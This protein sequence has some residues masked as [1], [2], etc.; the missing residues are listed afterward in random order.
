MYLS[1][2]AIKYPVFTTMVITALGV[3]GV[4][5]LWFLGVEL[6]PDVFPPVVVVS[7]QY[8]GAD[9][10]EMEKLVTRPI[11]DVV[12]ALKG[13]KQV[14]SV[15]TVGLSRVVVEFTLETPPAE[16]AFRVSEALSAIR[17]QLPL[18]IAE[19]SI[20][21]YDPAVEPIMLLGL[22]S[23][24][25]EPDQ[26]HRIALEDIKP[27]L[28]PLDGVASVE[29]MGGIE[30]EIQVLVDGERLVANRLSLHQVMK[31]LGEENTSVP[32]G[33]ILEPTGEVLLRTQGEF[34]SLEDILDVVVAQ[35]NGVPIY[36]RDVAIVYDTFK[37][38][39]VVA[40]I[41][42]GKAVIFSIHRQSGSNTL[43]VA[44]QV[45]AEL[46]S[47]APTLPS[48][49]Q[50]TTLRDASTRIMNSVR[51]VRNSLIL[52]GILAVVVVFL[53]MLDWRS[54]II[55]ALALP[56][57][58]IATF[59]LLYALGY[60]IN[61]M[62]LL[63]LS[64]AIGFLI[65]DSVVVRES[66][67]RHM[68]A[69]EDPA[70]AAQRG[71][72]EVGLAVMATTFTIVAV[73]VPVAFMSGAVGRFYQQFSLTVAAAVLV[74][75][76]VAFTLDPMLSSRFMRIFDKAE[77]RRT[78]IG[79]LLAGW[80]DLYDRLDGVY[81]DFLK[82]VLTHRA[83]V[84]VIAL[85]IFVAS[86]AVLPFIGREFLTPVD[87]GEF[88]IVM[89]MEPG[90][91]LYDMVNSTSILLR[92]LVD[93]PEVETVYT[94][95]GSLFGG[96][97][98]TATLGVKLK[99]LQEH[100][101]PQDEIVAELRRTLPSIPGARLSFT[102]TGGVGAASYQAPIEL[103]IR[104]PRSDVATRL[105]ADVANIVRQVKGA[106][107]VFASIQRGQ[108]EYHVVINRAKAGDYGLGMGEVATLLRT[109]VEGKIATRYNEWNREY[110]VRVRLIPSQRD[111]SRALENL[112]FTTSQG[113]QVYLRDVAS[114]APASAPARI[115]RVN[116]QRQVSVYAQVAG[117]SVGDV[118][119]E[120][121]AELAQLKLPP[122]YTVRFTSEVAQMEESFKALIGALILSV[123]FIYMILASLYGSFLHPFTIMLS[124]PLAII[125]ALMAL[126]LTGMTINLMSL[127][128]IV[129]LMGLVTKNA[130]LLVDY[131]KTLR[132]A[133]AS[134]Q[135]AVLT[136]APIRLRPILM[137]TLAMIFGMLPIA[138]GLGSEA[139]MRQPMAVAAIGGLIT[140]TLLTLAVVPVVYTLL[141][142]LVERWRSRRGSV[143]P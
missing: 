53:F 139:E 20:R 118:A 44:R 111:S 83:R 115:E 12:S 92:S 41:N 67:F 134:R 110:D 142:E 19:P 135:E 66:I 93:R 70:T 77:R 56:T 7:T 80:I 90:T 73:F 26:L 124:L 54:T 138:L 81:R 85:V 82:W 78:R 24:T 65:D 103:S 96:D 5:S 30:R 55:A 1:N 25:R 59:A 122:G 113:K 136:A 98:N 49:V 63:G 2:Q 61:L 126:F 117:R 62:T 107:D 28:E 119:R 42:R 74:S 109:M 6:F 37:D 131:T 91:R 47:I 123:I 10:K 94:A 97:I 13:L 127:I 140:S 141:D 15:S 79:R 143:N 17:P 112:L 101:R 129:L 99:P 21:R 35:A 75:L 18:G 33:R 71:T 38:V 40:G 95:I 137:T 88:N 72:T 23:K 114:V 104:G 106:E 27:R 22:S 84:L 45:H 46:Q 68:E 102:T 32:S 31:R 8:P 132:E 51:D 52:G 86:L 87:S 36:L 125:G 4:V 3:L 50:I 100:R 39:R 120:I 89:E 43:T 133:G 60:S 29:V 16:A 116:R 108:P 58:V 48:D 64:L 14:R 9:S 128:G 57:S 130:I 34:R 105:A 11:E 69:G 121:E 76:F